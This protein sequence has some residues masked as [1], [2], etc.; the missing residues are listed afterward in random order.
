MSRPLVIL[1]WELPRNWLLLRETAHI[2][3][4]PKWPSEAKVRL[5][6]SDWTKGSLRDN[7]HIAP[8]VTETKKL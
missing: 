1:W 8:H 3:A 5:S 4:D 2:P 7:E 6:D